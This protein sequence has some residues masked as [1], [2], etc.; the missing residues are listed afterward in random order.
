[1]LCPLGPGTFWTS[2]YV[3]QQN[4]PHFVF[5]FF[6]LQPIKLVFGPYHQEFH[7]GTSLVVQWLRRL[8]PGQGVWV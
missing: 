8:L 7:P 2:S 3:S 1:M 6:N 4:P 5:F